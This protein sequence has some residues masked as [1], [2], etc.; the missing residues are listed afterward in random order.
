MGRKSVLV[1]AAIALASCAWSPRST[2]YLLD[3]GYSINPVKGDDD[4]YA[5]EIHV[6]QLKRLGGE[7]QSPEVRRFVFERLTWHEGCKGAWQMLPCVA[8]GS[9]IRHTS[10]SVTIFARCAAS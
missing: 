4:A 10:R 7:I 8:D 3:E 5:V 2:W 9:C 6:N 1:C